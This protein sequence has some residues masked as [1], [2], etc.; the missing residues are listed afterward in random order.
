MVEA[1]FFKTTYKFTDPEWVSMWTDTTIQHISTG[2]TFDFDQ[3]CFGGNGSP[4]GCTTEE[5][6]PSVPRNGV[7]ACCGDYPARTEYST[8]ARQCCNNV[9]IPNDQTC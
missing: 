2:G 5:C 9:L 6:G 4:G 7:V 3:Q 8:A 1:H